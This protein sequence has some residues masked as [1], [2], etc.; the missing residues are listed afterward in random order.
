MEVSRWATPGGG[1][2]VTAG[3]VA[4]HKVVS[5]RN[6]DTRKC[7]VRSGCSVAN[8]KALQYHPGVAP[9]ITVPGDGNVS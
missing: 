9:P 5:V 4:Q 2:T 8:P 7:S 3:E 6:S 1:T